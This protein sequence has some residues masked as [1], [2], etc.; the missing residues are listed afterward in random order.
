MAATTR[1]QHAPGNGDGVESGYVGAADCAGSRHCGDGRILRGACNSN[2]AQPENGAANQAAVS[3]RKRR[4]FAAAVGD[5][6]RSRLLLSS[7]HAP[8]RQRCARAQPYAPGAHACRGALVAACAMAQP[9][10]QLAKAG[11]PRRVRASGCPRATA[12]GDNAGTGDVVLRTDVVL[13]GESFEGCG[14]VS[15]CCATAFRLG[16][17]RR[18][19]CCRTER[20]L[21]QFAVWLREM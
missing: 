3:F 15:C 8:E 7:D 1:V 4:R 9:G 16:V 13:R 18:I 14:L 21:A 10:S 5:G 2:G 12:S 19:G 11:K 17:F 20:T 6:M